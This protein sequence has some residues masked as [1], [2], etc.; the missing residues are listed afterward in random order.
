MYIYTIYTIYII[1]YILHICVHERRTFMVTD[2]G[3]ARVQD[4]YIE[5]GGPG[6]SNDVTHSKS[7]VGHA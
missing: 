7:E 1:Y 3:D 2:K 4:V 5:A 6:N